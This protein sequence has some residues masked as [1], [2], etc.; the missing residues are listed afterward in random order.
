MSDKI[1][2]NCEYWSR[3]KNSAVGDCKLT[4]SI[5]N[6]STNPASLATVQTDSL[7]PVITALVT[8]ADFGCN[9]FEEVSNND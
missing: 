2:K 8:K 5:D 3:W 9:Q 1:C 7:L 4:R 6:K